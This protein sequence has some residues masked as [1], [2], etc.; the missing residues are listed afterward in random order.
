MLNTLIITIPL[1]LLA[2]FLGYT[3]RKRL[4]EKK[5]QDAESQAEGIL[6]QAEKEAIDKRREV[7][8]E[9]KDL[10]YRIRQDFERETKDRR[11][12]ISNMEKRARRR[13]LTVGL[14]F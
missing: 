6:K 11:L 9:A 5:I 3:L 13:I 10:L 4:A 8:L 1:V 12:E 2:A 7:E 14:I